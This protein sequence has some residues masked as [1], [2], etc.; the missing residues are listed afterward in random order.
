MQNALGGGSIGVTRDAYQQ[1][2]GMDET[3]IGWGGEDNEF[4]DRAVTRRVWYWGYMPLVHLWHPAQPRKQEAENPMLT[5]YRQRTTIPPLDRIAELVAAGQSNQDV[6]STLF[7]S[8]KTVEVHLT[9]VYRKLGIR[10]RAELG[11][12][13]DHLAES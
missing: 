4:W 3:F 2:G 9:R 7:I 5:H 8:A 6:A 13:L 12:R 10:S 1:I 11:R